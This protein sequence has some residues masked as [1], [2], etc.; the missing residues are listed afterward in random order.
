MNSFFSRIIK[1]YFFYFRK[2]TI[3]NSKPQCN[4]WKL[5]F[6]TMLNWS[7]NSFD[8][9]ENKPSESCSFE[10]LRLY[11]WLTV[12]YVP[13]E[14]LFVSTQFSGL[15]LDGKFSNNFIIFTVSYFIHNYIYISLSSLLICFLLSDM[16]LFGLL[17]ILSAIQI[18]MKSKLTSL[19]FVFFFL[20][21]F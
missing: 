14:S 18:L 1:V 19:V 5:Y 9:S 16:G 11:F 17:V 20:T 4:I 2:F 15:I 8:T 7:K 6:S 3:L 10:L 21:Q 12:L 13:G